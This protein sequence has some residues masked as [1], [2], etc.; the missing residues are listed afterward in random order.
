MATC[1]RPVCILIFIFYCYSIFIWTHNLISVCVCMWFS[2]LS[3]LPVYIYVRMWFSKPSRLPVHV[4]IYDCM[5]RSLYSLYMY[6][7]MYSI[8]LLSPFLR[9][10]LLSLFPFL[11]VMLVCYTHILC[12][13]V[14][15]DRYFCT[16]HIHRV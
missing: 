5:H 12:I 7:Y 15:A 4:Y 13:L 1:T 9:L 16:P 11:S 14:Y 8:L 10:S 3:R 6:I 2:K